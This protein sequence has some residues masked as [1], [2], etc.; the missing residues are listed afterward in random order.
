MAPIIPLLILFA[1]LPPVHGNNSADQAG[2][3]QKAD[4]PAPADA[5]KK[6][7]AAI[8]ADSAEA[9]ERLHQN[10]PGAATRARMKRVADNIAEL[11]KQQD[12][13][14]KSPSSQSPPPPRPMDSDTPKPS[15]SPAPSQPKETRT[16]PSVDSS[17]RGKS[18]NGIEEMKQ[19]MN[20]ADWGKMPPRLRQEME[21]IGRDR[22][23]RNYEEMLRAYYRNI[24]D[25]SRRNAD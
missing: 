22:F 14:P 19:Q 6:I 12:P 24:A 2:S 11:L 20:N 1:V 21:A 23:I 25:S 8:D 7:I 5:R 17:K 9:F 10:D 16:Q 13:S 15:A 18:A 4:Q 3:G